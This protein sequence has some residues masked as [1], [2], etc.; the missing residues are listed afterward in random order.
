[1]D[2]GQYRSSKSPTRPGNKKPAF[3]SSMDAVAIFL[4]SPDRLHPRRDSSRTFQLLIMQRRPLLP[5]PGFVF[6]PNLRV[7]LTPKPGTSSFGL[8][9]MYCVF[10][11]PKNLNIS[12]KRVKF[13]RMAQ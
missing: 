5:F 3:P 1:M 12:P 13:H 8:P 6:N 7:R 4:L 10:F 2:P 11:W 9:S